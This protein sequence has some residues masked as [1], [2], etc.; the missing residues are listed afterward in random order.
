[1]LSKIK[2][3]REEREKEMEMRE[4]EQSMNHPWC[5]RPNPDVLSTSEEDP[6]MASTSTSAEL[7]SQTCSSTCGT[8][9]L[10]TS[11]G[12]V[13]PTAILPLPKSQQPRAQ[14]KRKQGKQLTNIKEQGKSKKKQTKKK[15]P[16]YS[17]Y[18][19]SDVPI[20][21]D[22]TSKCESSQ[23]ESSEP[24]ISD[25]SVGAFIIVNFATKCN[26]YH[27][28]GLVESL[29]GN[30]VN[31]RFLRGIR[32]STGKDKAGFAFKE[33]DVGSVP[34]NDVLKKLPKPQ[35]VGGTARR[36]QQ[37]IFPCNLV[38]RNVQ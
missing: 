27:Y 33:N 14:T 10:L 17:S 32:G 11:P 7:P 6:P 26:S 31:A 9:S 8:D 22:D 18:E 15:T 30:E 21:L 2:K 28:I 37:L 20:P 19:E 16:V 34:L 24:D 36:E 38:G 1:M 23:D 35:K 13:S 3:L 5:D 4:E 12:Y 25:L 29:E